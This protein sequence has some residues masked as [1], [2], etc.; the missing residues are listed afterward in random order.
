MYGTYTHETGSLP[1]YLYM[2]FGARNE[3]VISGLGG[4]EG[5]C[6]GKEAIKV[7][8]STAR[9]LTRTRVP[10]KFQP[11]NHAGLAGLGESLVAEEQH[12]LS[13]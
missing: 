8:E 11:T 10:D 9:K 12:S 2:I 4:G 6:R 3:C 13:D 5:K 7:R 1:L